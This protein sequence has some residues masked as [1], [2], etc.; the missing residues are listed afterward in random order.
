MNFDSVKNLVLEEGLME[1]YSDFL[2]SYT[3][4]IAVYAE[5]QEGVPLS[6]SELDIL[7]DEYHYIVEVYALDSVFG[8]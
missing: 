8:Y 6:E 2:D 4:S 5:N 3:H 1:T 7:N